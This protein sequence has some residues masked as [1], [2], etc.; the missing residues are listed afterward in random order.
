M[1]LNRKGYML[2]EIIISF[3]LA[4]SIAYYLLNLTYKFK[5]MDEDIY[6]STIF[7]KDKILITKNIMNDIDRGTV[8][9]IIRQDDY[10]LTF[11]LHLNNDSSEST[12]G[13]PRRISISKDRKTITYGIPDDDG[14]KQDDISYYTKTIDDALIIKSISIKSDNSDNSQSNYF[15]IIIEISSLY[16]D[17]DNYDIKLFGQQFNTTQ[18]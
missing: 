1:K 4:M 5:N 7:I 10:N 8:S 17:D 18:P 13:V 2:V 9:N 12:D 15:S 11:N 6:M 3:T 16:N 14:W